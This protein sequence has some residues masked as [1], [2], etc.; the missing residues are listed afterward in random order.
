[1]VKILWDLRLFALKAKGDGMVHFSDPLCWR[2]LLDI[3]LI[4]TVLE[5]SDPILVIFGTVV[6]CIQ[7]FG[8]QLGY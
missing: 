5:T 4:V 1:M 3:C 2:H 6:H 7:S 8:F